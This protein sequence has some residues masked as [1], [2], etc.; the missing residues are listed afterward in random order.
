VTDELDAETSAADAAEEAALLD[1]L[2]GPTATPPTS[3]E[4][5]VEAAAE[6]DPQALFN[7]LVEAGVPL[8]RIAVTTTPDGRVSA[9]AK[10]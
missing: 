9:V 2:T 5:E 1:Y 4:V 3:D 10:L 8:A 6:A 7:E